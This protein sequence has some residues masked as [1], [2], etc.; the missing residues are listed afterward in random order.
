MGYTA[1]SDDG[2]MALVLHWFEGR[3]EGRK[4]QVTIFVNAYVRSEAQVASM[5]VSLTV[6]I[7]S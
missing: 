5:S 2:D 4:R 7:S 6:L 1:R 3:K